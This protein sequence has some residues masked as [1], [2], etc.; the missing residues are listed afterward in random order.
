MP[1]LPGVRE[2]RRLSA[3]MRPGHPAGSRRTP[4]DDAKLDA[5]M[6]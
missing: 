1:R 3:V 5:A 4:S 2:Q 6:K